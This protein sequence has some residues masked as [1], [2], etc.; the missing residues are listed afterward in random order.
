LND[1]LTIEIQ[2]LQDVQKALER[3]AQKAYSCGNLAARAGLILERQIKQNASGRPGPKV[4][5]GRLRASIAT[6]VI[7]QNTARVGTGVEY[8]PYVEYGHRI[9]GRLWTSGIR[10]THGGIIAFTDRMTPAYPF[11]WRAIDETKELVG[12]EVKIF[13]HELGAEFQ[14]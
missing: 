1:A 7:D 11:F 3:T 5:T 12:D 8:A 13:A 6:E 2:G 4:Q 14:K 9:R 10:Y